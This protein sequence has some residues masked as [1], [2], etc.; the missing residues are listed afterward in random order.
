MAT[1]SDV[2]SMLRPNGGY[3]IYGD[4]YAGIEFVE[5]EP[6]S[7]EEYDIGLANYD[8]WKAAKDAE[9]AKNKAD[10]VATLESL[11]LTPEQIKALGL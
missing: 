8:S 9:I 6:F 10:G 5:C 11:G 4:D 3:L 7:E 1:A 2:C